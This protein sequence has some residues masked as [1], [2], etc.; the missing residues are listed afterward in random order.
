MQG[1]VTDSVFVGTDT[2]VYVTL[3]GGPELAVLV[4]NLDQE[5]K[6]GE[7]VTLS[8]DPADSRLLPA[9]QLGTVEE[10]NG[11]QPTRAG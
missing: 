2:R 10:G 7:K 3:K 4:R 1:K 8:Y 6:R 11:G 9:A 5:F